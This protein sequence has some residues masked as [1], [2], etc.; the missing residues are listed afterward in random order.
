MHVNDLPSEILIEI[1]DQAK[2]SAPFALGGSTI[3]VP[4]SQVCRAWRVIALDS[5]ALWNDVRLSSRSSPSKLDQLVSRSKGSL[6]SVAIDCASVAPQRTTTLTQYGA[7]LDPLLVHRERICALDFIAP[8]HVLS[9]LVVT[10]VLSSGYPELRRLQVVQESPPH[11]TADEEI[12]RKVPL[13]GLAIFAPQ[14]HSLSIT[15]TTPTFHHFFDRLKELHV[16]ESGYF[17]VSRTPNGSPKTS[18]PLFSGLERLTITSSPLPLLV[19]IPPTDTQL[20]AFTLST[21]RTADIPPCTLAHLLCTLRMPALEHLTIH[22]LHG[23]LW[24][25]FVRW[26]ADAQY[27]A[28]RSVT[29]ESLTL[30]GIDKRCL[31]AFA[32]VGTL[33]LIDVDPEPV[34]RIL[35]SSPDICR[36]VHEIDIGLNGMLQIP[37]RG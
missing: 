30:T 8:P 9:L 35:E 7:L 12:I 31:H 28:L 24:D 13:W 14:L 5:G 15:A 25:E 11:L 27:P 36:D 18:L 16:K 4:I 20:V 17:A 19:D 34:V 2:S 33:R 1:F 37:G 10:R 32:S 29:F 22:S 6:I 3:T 26:L 21:L 23:Y